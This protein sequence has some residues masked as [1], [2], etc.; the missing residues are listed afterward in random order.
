MVT[1]SGRPALGEP[2]PRPLSVFSCPP[3]VEPDVTGLRRTLTM[4]RAIPAFLTRGLL[5]FLGVSSCTVLRSAGA[6]HLACARP[7]IGAWNRVAP[8]SAGLPYRR[9]GPP[10]RWAPE[11]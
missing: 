6:A 10:G 1:S 9:N 3:A 4:G 7:F 5:A 11:S 8:A 2:M